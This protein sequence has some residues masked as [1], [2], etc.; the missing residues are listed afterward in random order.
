MTDKMMHRKRNTCRLCTGKKLTR[1]VHLNPTPLADQYIEK[2][3]LDKAQPSYPLDLYFCN[4]CFHLQLL[5]IINPDELF[6]NYIYETK[7]SPGLVNHFRAYAS[8]VHSRLGDLSGKR[9]LDIGSNDGTLLHF[10]QDLGMD[11][12]GVDAAREIAENATAGG[13]ET[14][15]GFFDGKMAH[16]IRH[17]GEMDLITANNVYAHADNLSE[18][19]RGIAS[20]LK[21][22]GVFIFEV[23][24]LPDLME[25]AVFDFVYHEHLCYHS[26][27][28]LDS[29]LKRNGLMLFDVHRVP[30]KGGS[31]RGY[32]KPAD[33][34]RRVTENVTRFITDE[35]FKRLDTKAPYIAFEKRINGIR[36]RARQFVDQEKKQGKIFYGYGACAT[37]TTLMYHFGLEKDLTRI[38]DDNVDRQG[39]FSPGAHIPVVGPDAIYREKPDYI[40]ITAWRFADAIMANHPAYLESGGAFILPLPE[41]KIVRKQ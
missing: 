20:L 35:R 25:N 15:H 38:V 2:A 14:L 6:S 27:I 10:F 16:A 28:S 22:E 11:V 26:I 32:A 23:S 9:A 34:L 19:T 29:F 39:L 4:D 31:I 33:G 7:S 30:T 5:D 3:F 1:V 12:L 18:I 13:L 24:Y 17:R 40:L 8:D 41:V 21:P 37:A 36:D